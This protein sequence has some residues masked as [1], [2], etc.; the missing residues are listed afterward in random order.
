[1]NT[2]KGPR[3]VGERRTHE[4]RQRTQ[5]LRRRF[6]QTLGLG[7]VSLP[8]LRLLE[9]SAVHAA[10]DNLPLSFVGLYHPHGASSPLFRRRAEDTETSFELNY[11]EPIS[12]AQSVL[13][14][15]DDAATYG[16]SFKDKVIVL[17]GL[18][19]TTG[20]VGHDAPRCLFTGAGWQESPSLD[21]F[22]AV[23]QG[24][25]AG[26]P[27]SSLV[28]GVG[29]FGTDRDTLSFSSAGTQLP[30]IIDPSETFSMVFSRFVATDDAANEA[31]QRRQ[32]GASVID[33]VRADINRLK[34]RLAEPEA[35]KLDQH[36]TSLRELEKQLAAFEASCSW[37]A[38]P[39]EF[40]AIERFKGG[41]PYFEQITNLQIDLL[42][43]A[44]VCDLT[45]FATLWM[46]D[47]S[48][49]AIAG[50]SITHPAYG[51]IDVHD[52]IAHRY[53][54]PYDGSHGETVTEGVPESWAALGVQNRYSYGKAARLLQ[55]LEQGGILDHTLVMIATEMG[56]PEAHTSEN[57]PIVLAGGAGGRLAMGRHI[58][59]K[60]NCATGEG[61]CGGSTSTLISHNHLLV[62]L[63]N[64]YGVEID[65]FGKTT[66][67]PTHAVGGLPELFA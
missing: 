47:L 59:L 37:P 21:Q 58:R 48:S 8:F 60:E 22:L 15:F 16:R 64:V 62:S 31:K 57:V 19:I 6:L 39:P 61:G 13:A 10:E 29:L 65:T 18:D 24:L 41:E 45:R 26:T 49:G 7:A 33:F 12:G 5:R 38:K 43:Q 27:F 53:W 52:D 55:K 32:E 51:N 44:I 63:A 40:A 20:L 66:D 34:G 30:R 1:M 25:G 54:A 56:N 23:D 46:A 4:Q 50:T 28:L 67:D 3:L 35:K 11:V 42:A 2:S 36:L 14:P 9:S 17:D